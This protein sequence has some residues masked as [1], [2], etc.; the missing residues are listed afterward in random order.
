[1][2]NRR[3]LRATLRSAG[4]QKELAK[5]WLVFRT[6]MINDGHGDPSS[7]KSNPIRANRVLGLFVQWLYDQ[8]VKEYFNL[9]KHAILAVQTFLPGL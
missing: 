6:F 4:Y 2:T 9:A 7:F 5:A 1:M 3:N 8:N